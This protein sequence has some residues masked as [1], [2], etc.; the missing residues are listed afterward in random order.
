MPSGIKCYNRFLIFLEISDPGG[1][2]GF[3]ELGDQGGQLGVG[4]LE[5]ADGGFE[6]LNDGGVHL[7][8]GF[9]GVLEQEADI[10]IDVTQQRTALF[11]DRFDVADLVMQLL[12]KLTRLVV[13]H[14]KKPPGL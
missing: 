10:L 5:V 11:I 13:I 9:G 12:E 14:G 8:T 2:E 6:A 1:A 3:E 4:D 7:H